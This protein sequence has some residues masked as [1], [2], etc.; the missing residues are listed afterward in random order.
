VSKARKGRAAAGGEGGKGWLSV[1]GC[2]THPVLLL[3][4]LLLMIVMKLL[5][6][7]LLMLEM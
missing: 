5:L 7:P 4:L 1:S 6:L 2:I 3:L